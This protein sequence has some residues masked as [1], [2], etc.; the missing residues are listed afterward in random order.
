LRGM[1]MEAEVG[2]RGVLSIGGDGGGA[3]W[4]VRCRS[5]ELLTLEVV[6]PVGG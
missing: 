4:L 5:I 3:G 6:A 1:E 2:G